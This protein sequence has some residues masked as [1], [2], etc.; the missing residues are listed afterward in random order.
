MT[1]EQGE[2]IIGHLLTLLDY[3]GTIQVA[4]IATVEALR[5]CFLA[6]LTIAF[7]TIVQALLRR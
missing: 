3:A 6:L 5:W 2:T 4:A 1:S 7:A